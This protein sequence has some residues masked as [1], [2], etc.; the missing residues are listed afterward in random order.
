MIG[1]GH[2]EDGEWQFSCFVTDRLTETHEAQIIDDWFDHM[3][4]VQARLD[5]GS[6]ANIF[7]WSDAEKNFLQKGETS[8]FERHDG[9]NWPIPNWFDF[10]KLVMKPEPV[11]VRGAHGFGLKPITKALNILGL[12]DI[13]W[14]D[15]TTDGLGAMTGAWWCDEEA[16]RDGKVLKDYELMG[17][18]EAYNEIDCKAMFEI[19]NYLRLKH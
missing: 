15:G 5:P 6:T 3:V 18:I 1:C 14:P 8:A 2:I 11:V 16:E 4:A 19:I 10:W 12:I 7:H 17:D 9:H 13:E